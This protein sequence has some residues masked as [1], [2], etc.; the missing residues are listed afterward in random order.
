MLMEISSWYVVARC[1]CGESAA[2][3]GSAVAAGEVP[4]PEE[5]SLSFGLSEGAS[6]MTIFQTI[7]V[8][9]TKMDRTGVVQEA[10]ERKL[11]RGDAF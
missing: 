1:P 6:E 10:G 11:T 7:F 3:V 5:A 4:I 9:S 8:D 2:H